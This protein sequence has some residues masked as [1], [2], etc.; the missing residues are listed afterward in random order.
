MLT[1]CSQC[2][3][4]VHKDGTACPTCGHQDEPGCEGRCDRSASQVV[5]TFGAALVGVVLA[6]C[7]G[8]PEDDYYYYD[9][10]LDGEDDTTDTIDDVADDA[11]G[12]TSS[13]VGE[14]DADEDA[15]ADG[16]SDDA[17][18]DAEDDVSGADS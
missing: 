13:D 6:A 16:S 12:D 2:G 7:Y 18:S 8:L 9:A 5:R 1:T 4:H 10:D 15:S 17:S 14:P 11:S 3:T